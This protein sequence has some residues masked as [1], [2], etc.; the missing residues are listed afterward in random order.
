MT[1]LQLGGHERG[2]KRVSQNQVFLTVMILS[3]I[4]CALGVGGIL[5]AGKNLSVHST[6]TIAISTAQGHLALEA[7]RAGASLWSAF[8][9]NFNDP[10][11]HLLLQFIVI[12]LATRVIGSLFRRF[13]QP[14]VIGEITAGILLGPTLL[15][16]LWPEASAFVFAKDSL[17]VLQLFSQI[18][19]C[20]FV[21]AIGLELDV[22]HLRHRLQTALV[23]S[24]MSI[25]VP[26]LLGVMVAFVIFPWFGVP[27]T[28]FVTF[29][30]F[31]GIAMS[32]TAF[33][34]LARILADRGIT[35][36]PLGAMA[37]ACAAAGDAAAWAILAIV[38]AVGRATGLASAFVGLGLVML[39]V[40]I[41][42]WGVRPFLA[43]WFDKEEMLATISG[44]MV[45]VLILM[46]AASFA[47]QVIGIHALFGAF[48]AG[49]VMPPSQRFRE[50]LIVRLES[51]S[52]TFLLPLFFAFSGLRTQLGSLDATSWLICAGIIAL[53]TVGKLGGSMLPARLMGMSWNEAFSL[54]ALMNTR[55]LVELIA[56]NIGYDVGI[57]SPKVFSMLV[58]MAL[59]TTFMAGPL[60]NLAE[61][62]YKHGSPRYGPAA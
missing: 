1:I 39:F 5:F 43:Y 33:P 14:S 13:G 58:L 46:T 26:Y 21:F 62:H 20:L 17:G 16:W 18:G 27:G 55:G 36:T 31:M 47:T 42:L 7:H 12:L 41:M 24:Q 8:E 54:G 23:V 52:S 6:E 10:L 35:K 25:G 3:V 11:A 59:I 50:N 57:L 38:V 34:V 9:E 4:I 2:H 53:A 29:A 51:F 32:I 44:L 19:V 49:A 28:S 45:P 56:L 15:G 48:L 37:L 60:L 22:G 30:L 40:A 61:V